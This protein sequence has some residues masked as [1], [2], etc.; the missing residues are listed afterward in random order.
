MKTLREITMK[1]PFRRIKPEGYLSNAEFGGQ[2]INDTPM[3]Q[4]LT[5]GDFLREYYPTGHRINDHAYYPDI[6]RESYEAEYDANGYETGRKIR[7]VYKELVPRCSFALQQIFTIKR[8][9]HLCGNDIKFELNK[10][11]PTKAERMRFVEFREGWLGK[12]MEVAFFELAESVCVTGDGAI[13][14]F[15]SDGSFGWKSLSYKNGDM[16]YPHYGAD[17][18]LEVFARKFTSMDDEGNE[19]TDWLEVWDSKMYRRYKRN[20]KDGQKI[21]DRIARMFNMDGWRLV[22][23]KPHSFP[24]IP[25]VY[26]RDDDGPCWSSGQ[27]NIENFELAF[28][29][30]SHNNKAF[31][32]PILMLIGEGDNF[33]VT[34][35]VDGTIKMISMS[36]D[37]KAE[38]LKGQSASDSFLKELEIQERMAYESTFSVR[39]P[40]LKSGD[41]PAAALKILYSPAVEMGI[42]NQHKYQKAVDNLVEI[43]AFG[44]GLESGKT[45]DFTNLP[46]KSWIEVYVHVNTSSVIQDLA[47]AVQNGFCS[48]ETAS[49]NI[50]FYA[51]E[52]EYNRI[53]RENK[54]AQENDLLYQLELEK[55]KLKEE[56]EAT[57]AE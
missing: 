33:S 3:F 38:Y 18:E 4:I 29:Q 50:T 16:L 21:Q 45:L 25:V 2:S 44:M 52:G 31:G 28:S 41:L 7:R 19:I 54:Q 1:K 15:I 9:T 23:S 49:E 55:A 56:D 8:L 43:Y 47:T 10:H 14:G 51:N 48:K 24:K 42:T 6:Y 11:E 12:N 30:M 22:E 40:E 37:D 26:F 36:K 17:G 20:G 46:V 53:L 27:D 34:N 57:D 13:V 32:E 5:Q 39:P 35:G